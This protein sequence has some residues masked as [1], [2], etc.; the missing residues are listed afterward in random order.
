MGLAEV[1]SGGVLSRGDVHS[2]KGIEADAKRSNQNGYHRRDAAVVLDLLRMVAYRR[3]D[4]SICERL[5]AWRRCEMDFKC[6]WVLNRWNKRRGNNASN[7]RN[8]EEE[9]KK[10][11]EEKEEEEKELVS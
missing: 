10:K 5:V 2:V 7:E 3:P 11:E 8:K 9:E 1:R 4:V 6:G